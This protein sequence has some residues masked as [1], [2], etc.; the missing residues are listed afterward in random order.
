MSRC[1]S[2]LC[3][4][5]SCVFGRLDH[6][7]LDGLELCSLLVHHGRNIAKELVQFTDRLLY[8]S[9]LG[10]SLNDQVLLKVNF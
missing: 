2:E 9:Y 6:V 4:G 5:A 7:A 3:V 10:F 1:M 8:L